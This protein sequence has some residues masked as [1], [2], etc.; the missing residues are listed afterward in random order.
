[1]RYMT[2]IVAE[3]EVKDVSRISRLLGKVI[4]KDHGSKDNEAQ[5]DMNTSTAARGRT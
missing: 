1:M 5:S 4:R 2:N 3:R